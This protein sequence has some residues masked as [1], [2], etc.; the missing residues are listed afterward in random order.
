MDRDPHDHPF[1]FWTFPLFQTY[2]EVVYDQERECF[3]TVRVP[4]WR[5]TY[6]PA[7][8]THRIISCDR[9]WPLFTLVLRGTHQRDW[10]FWV[11]A[12]ETAKRI[13]I[14]WKTYVNDG[15]GANVEG[16]DDVC[17]GSH[18]QGGI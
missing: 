15:V 1:E 3:S 10:G 8:H 11:H 2:T 14:P 9:G 7:K 16:R 5:W 4:R 6:R 13:F 17:P 12:K 18:Q